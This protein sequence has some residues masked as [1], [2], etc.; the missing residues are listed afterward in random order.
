MP[1]DS[2]EIH[3]RVRVFANLRRYVSEGDAAAGLE[4]DLPAGATLQDVVSRL[5]LPSE[6]VRVTFV[7]GRARPEDW[8]LEPDDEIGIFPPIGG[9]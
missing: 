8:R 9:G 2:S 3:V 6:Q 7:N 1:V 5:R 4:L